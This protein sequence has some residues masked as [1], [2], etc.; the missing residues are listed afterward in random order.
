MLERTSAVPPFVELVG[1]L[2]CKVNWKSSL[3]SRPSVLKPTVFGVFGG[4]RSGN[5]FFCFYARLLHSW[6]PVMPEIKEETRK[7]TRSSALHEI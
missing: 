7:P 6:E 1:F 4:V 5:L 3:N 2:N